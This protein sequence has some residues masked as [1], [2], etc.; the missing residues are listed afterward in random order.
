MPEL[1]LAAQPTAPMTPVVHE[2]MWR[3]DDLSDTVTLGLQP[4]SSPLPT[5][6]QPGQFN[7]LWAFGVGE[8][9][10]SHSRV[11]FDGTLEHTIRRVGAVT[12]S[13]CSSTV[14]DHIGV[15]GPFGEGWQPDL[16]HGSDVIIVA[17]GLGYA[18]LRPLLDTIDAHRSAYRA[19]T[20]LVGARSPDNLLHAAE[21][22]S[23]AER[24][25][26]TV[27]VTVD[28]P[29]AGWTGDVGVVTRF[30]DRV[31]ID[32]DHTI[33]FVC[34]PEIMMRFTARALVD[35]GIPAERVR[36]SLERNMHCAIGHCGH[37]QLG[38]AFVCKDGPV[39][40]WADAEPLLKVAER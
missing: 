16:A 35:H 25:D 17:G 28:I 7:M 23:L 19:I 31:S 37:C 20:L 40:T 2:V 36:L 1:E 12:E 30:I 34:G 21:I 10:I 38:A 33:G 14:G 27:H 32:P 26:M 11:G 15:R 6:P 3:R 22:A 39:F 8:A 29:S 18:P 5:P 24:S 4:V 9:P 13:L